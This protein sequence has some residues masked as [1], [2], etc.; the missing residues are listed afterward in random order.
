[1]RKADSLPFRILDDE[2]PWLGI[3][4]HVEVYRPRCGKRHREP[5]P[6]AVAGSILIEHVSDQTLPRKR[7]YHYRCIVVV[8][9]RS[10]RTVTVRAGSMNGQRDPETFRYTVPVRVLSAGHEQTQQY[11]TYRDEPGHM[12]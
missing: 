7:I 6:G 4:Y 1:M 9:G 8:S 2:E 10:L 12:V 11:R 3:E 5:C